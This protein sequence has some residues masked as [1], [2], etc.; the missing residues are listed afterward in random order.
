MRDRLRRVFSVHQSRQQV[1][2]SYMMYENPAHHVRD[3]THSFGLQP[4]PL[5]K[6]H[7]MYENPARQ[8]ELATR[9]RLAPLGLCRCARSVLVA[10]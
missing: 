5:C 3:D 7:V 4:N 10:S 6:S 1:R 2:I 9:T 8:F